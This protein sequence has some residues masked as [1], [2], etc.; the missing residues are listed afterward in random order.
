MTTELWK[1]FCVVGVGRHAQTKLIPAL[2]ANGQQIVGL[3]S[4]QLPE[5]LPCGPVF[6]SIEAALNALPV[7][8]VFI[9]ATPPT[10]HFEQVYTVTEAGRDVI[11]EKPAF[12]SKKEACEIAILCHDRGTVLVEG[13]MYRHTA[14]YRRF[15][16][17][18]DAR[19]D[20]IDALDAKF[21][22]PE[23][24][25]DSFRQENTIASSCLFDMGCYV[26]SLLADLELSLDALH[27]TP[28]TH[29]WNGWDEI[30]IGGL[31]DDIKVRIK[32]GVA[33]TYQNVVEVCI[34]DREK[35]KFWPFFYGRPSERWISIE[36]HETIAKETLD[37][38]DAFQ[39]M[40]MVPRSQLVA[41]QPKRLEQIIR[42][43]SLLEAL[44]RELFALRRQEN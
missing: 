1:R 3:V 25:Q 35:A 2:L 34:R 18:W 11:V 44:G 29:H 21:L 28:V 40:F 24:P 36:S 30:N 14:L 10:M 31:L 43:T 23:V 5:Q 39:R 26:I 9:I 8:T 13:L 20:Q 33:P 37:D 12:V 19:R 38:A 7:D 17:Y 4:S 15:L 16:E 32:I 27:L 41:D 22:I 6:A 42:V